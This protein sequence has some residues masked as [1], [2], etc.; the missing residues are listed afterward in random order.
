MCVFPDHVCVILNIFML[1][2]SCLCVLFCYCSAQQA[3]GFVFIFLPRNH[4][5]L[6]LVFFH[7]CFHTLP[8][9]GA[10]RECCTTYLVLKL[11]KLYWQHVVVVATCLQL[12]VH[13]GLHGS[14]LGHNVLSVTIVLLLYGRSCS[15]SLRSLCGRQIVPGTPS[16][17]RYLTS[18]IGS[19]QRG[20]WWVLHTLDCVH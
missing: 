12:C 11:S 7:C 3:H 10:L 15:T 19:R 8:R 2:P 17:T 4:P 6:S 9:F 14:C 18:V 5:A 20:A 13:N 1:F 16:G